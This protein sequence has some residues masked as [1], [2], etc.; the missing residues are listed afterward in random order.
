MT[1]SGAFNV[2]NQGSE[3]SSN[4][5][6]VTWLV[7]DRASVQIQVLYPPE[8]EVLAVEGNINNLQSSFMLQLVMPRS[9][10]QT[11]TETVERASENSQEPKA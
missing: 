1:I 8:P 6:K 4:L 5:T 2:R 9:R 10:T 7:G 3:N 11:C